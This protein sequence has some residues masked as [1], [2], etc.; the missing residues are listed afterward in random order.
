MSRGQRLNGMRVVRARLDDNAE[1]VARR[2]LRRAF[3]VYAGATV[4]LKPGEY[5]GRF[6]WR[7]QREIAEGFRRSSTAHE[8]TTAGARAV[9]E[10]PDGSITLFGLAVIETDEDPGRWG[11][12][13]EIAS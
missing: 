3:L 1:D 11:L 8:E 7:I 6:R 13:L 2:V 10:L 12:T 9:R 4:G 5:A